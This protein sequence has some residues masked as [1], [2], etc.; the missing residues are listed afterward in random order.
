[1]SEP[2]MISVITLTYNKF[3]H[4]P[5]TI[6]SV[7]AQDYP[8]IEYIISDDASE[9]F[10][11]EEVME[12]IRTYQKSN[13]TRFHLVRNETNIGIVRNAN[14]AYQ[15]AS[16]AYMVNLSCGDVFFETSTLSK[17]A[18]R[19][20]SS[21]AQ[22]LVASRIKYGNDLKPL[23]LMPHYQERELIRQYDTPLKQ[24]KAF[25]LGRDCDMASGS[26]MYYARDTIEK[27]GWFDE[28][29]RLWEDGPFLAKYLWQSPLEFAYDIISIWYESG[30]I[31]SP[32]SG[33]SHSLTWED[34]KKFW[35]SDIFQHVDAFS[36]EEKAQLFY[37]LVRGLDRGTI[38][39]ILTRLRF[40]PEWRFFRRHINLRRKA[41]AKDPE[42]I[43]EA[44]KSPDLIDLET[45]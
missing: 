16:G 10:P 40:F 14:K 33:A 43:C 27:M 13:I 1:M 11:E 37:H 34:E 5:L 8:N 38:D 32:A 7:L 44:L 9:R 18:A 4:L 21:G 42:Y 17:I 6:K 25:L 24:Y 31:S 29:Y 12:L 20:Q 45:L 36:A 19:F 2:K 39:K 22:V 15:M 30:G 23:C 26:A 35:N 41:L 3:E 28:R